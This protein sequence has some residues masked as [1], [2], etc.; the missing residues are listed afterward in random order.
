MT[1]YI[2]INMLHSLSS[3]LPQYP[4]RIPGRGWTSRSRSEEPHRTEVTSAP[5]WGACELFLRP[6]SQGRE[7][8]TELPGSCTPLPGFPHVLSTNWKNR[9]EYSSVH[10]RNSKSIKKTTCL[11][12]HGFRRFGLFIAN[13]Q[14]HMLASRNSSR[15]LISQVNPDRTFSLNT[16]FTETVQN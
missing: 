10:L 2:N 14:T 9:A 3:T 12:L 6:P 11:M 4:H 16:C 8:L 13:K 1:N 5:H 15:D 7:M